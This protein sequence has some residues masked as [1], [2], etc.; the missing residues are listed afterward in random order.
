[1]KLGTSLLSLL[2]VFLISILLSGCSA[3]RSWIGSSVEAAVTERVEA[4]LTKY[5]DKKFPEVIAQ[6]DT[7]ADAKVSALEWKTW[8][9]S[10]GGLAFLLE[11]LRRHLKN[12]KAIAGNGSAKPAGP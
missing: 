3:V 4:K 11:L 9:T 12:A 5:V 8:L 6:A 10:G 1:M 2:L 7:N